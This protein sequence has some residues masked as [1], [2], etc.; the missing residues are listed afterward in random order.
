MQ[1]AK[2]KIQQAAA[3]CLGN[4]SL[5]CKKVKIG[6]SK[7]ANKNAINTG[8]IMSFPRQNIKA[9]EIKLTSIK[10]SLA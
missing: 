7:T 3:K 4:L 10:A 6:N 8:V 9:K 1:A 5:E 2:S